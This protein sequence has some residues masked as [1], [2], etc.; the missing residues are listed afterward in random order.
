MKWLKQVLPVQTPHIHIFGLYFIKRLRTHIFLDELE[1]FGNIDE[2]TTTSNGG[3]VM[4]TG[5]QIISGTKKLLVMRLFLLHI[6]QHNVM[7]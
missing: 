7:L 2:T 3:A 5:N 1:I 6:L 4:V